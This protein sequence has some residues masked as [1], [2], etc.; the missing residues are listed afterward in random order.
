MDV[1]SITISPVTATLRLM[2]LSFVGPMAVISVISKA[3][4]RIIKFELFTDNAS[5]SLTGVIS[6]DGAA[7]TFI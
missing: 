6:Q 7:P 5:E 4:E 3:V 2:M 1:E